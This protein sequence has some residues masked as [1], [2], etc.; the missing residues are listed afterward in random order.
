MDIGEDKLDFLAYRLIYG[1]DNMEHSS[2]KM[3]EGSDTKL[4]KDK[5]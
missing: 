1:K 5:E 2:D 4:Q 3:I